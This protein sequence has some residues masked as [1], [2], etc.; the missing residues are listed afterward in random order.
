MDK[1]GFPEMALNPFEHRLSVEGLYSEGLTA[2]GIETLQVNIGLTCNLE[3]THCHV[4]SSPRRKEQMDWPTM[5]QVLRVARSLASPIV[6]I[7]GGA[8]EMNPHFRRFVTELRNDGLAVMVRTNLTILLEPGYTDLPA[9]F[10]DHEIRLAASLPCYLEEN[11]DRQRGEGVY[12]KSIEVLLHLNRLGY[13]HEPALLLDLLYNPG[14]P[15]LPPNERSLEKEYRQQLLDRFGISFNHLH[16]MTNMPIGQFSGDLKRHHQLESYRSLLE[17]SFNP[18]SVEY[19]M[20]RRQISVN[21]DGTLF[22]CD[23]NLALRLP[24]TNGAPEHVTLFD[25]EALAHRR[26]RTG[27]HCFGC[28]AGSGSSCGGALVRE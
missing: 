11:V 4:A 22:D 6:D 25:V 16:T 10:R 2:N 28:T 7:T 1:D 14:G 17:G 13:G 5:E 8:P 27:G 3:C 23:F 19:L 26:I 20:C 9:F 15:Q 21:W 18:R 12:R 24:L